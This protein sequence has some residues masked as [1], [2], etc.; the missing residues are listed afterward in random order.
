MLDT[1]IKQTKSVAFHDKQRPTNYALRGQFS[2][3]DHARHPTGCKSSI[4]PPTL[5]A[6]GL[7][8]YAIDSNR[9][10]LASF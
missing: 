4:D 5:P 10:F 6:T 8:R 9:R 7:T 2:L 1:H 3:A